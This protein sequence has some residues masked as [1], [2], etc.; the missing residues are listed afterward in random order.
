ME[1]T[2]YIYHTSL[3]TISGPTARSNYVGPIGPEIVII[4]L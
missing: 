4:D 3:I 2:S 1:W